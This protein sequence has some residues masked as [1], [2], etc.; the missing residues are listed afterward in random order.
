MRNRNKGFKNGIL[1][2]A[3]GL[4]LMLACFLPLKFLVGVLA[5]VVIILGIYCAK[6]T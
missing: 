5:T 1:I 2:A 3:F 6:C 4:G